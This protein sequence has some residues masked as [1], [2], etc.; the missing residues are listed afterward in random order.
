MTVLNTTVRVGL[1]EKLR[2]EQ[3]LADGKEVKYVDIMYLLKNIQG[4][5]NK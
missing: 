4:R 5:E 2:V 3:C 1:K